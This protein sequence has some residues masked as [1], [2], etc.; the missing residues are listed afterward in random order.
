MSLNL[1]SAYFI[2]E[3]H[4]LF[5]MAIHLFM[6]LIIEYEMRLKIG[7]F[8]SCNVHVLFSLMT[9]FQQK[10]NNLIW[11]FCAQSVQMVYKNAVNNSDNSIWFISSNYLTTNWINEALTMRRAFVW[12]QFHLNWYELWELIWLLL[13]LRCCCCFCSY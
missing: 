4:K 7:Y 3:T 13:W 8:F 2:L 5:A 12:H 11:N 9:Y 10:I 1:F 6:F